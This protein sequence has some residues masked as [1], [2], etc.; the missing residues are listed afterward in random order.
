MYKGYTVFFAARF[1]SRGYP[2]AAV[3]KHLS[4]VKFSERKTSLKNKNRTTR[5]KILPLIKRDWLSAA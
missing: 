1:K 5:K 3:E 4:E 2:A